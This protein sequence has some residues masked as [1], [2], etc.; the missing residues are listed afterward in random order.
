MEGISNYRQEDLSN[1]QVVF[2]SKRAD[3][4]GDGKIETVSL[5][6]TVLKSGIV[7]NNIKIIISNDVSRDINLKVNKG[8]NPK[9]FLGD[10]TSDGLDDVFVSIESGNTGREGFFYIYSFALNNEQKIFDYENFNNKYKYDVIYD[11]N[12]IVHVLSLFSPLNY[13]IN[14]SNRRDYLNTLY[15]KDGTL[16]RPTRGIVSPIIELRPIK[17]N[18][19]YNL[20]AIQRIVGYYNAD[21]LGMIVT[22]LHFDK[23]QKE[24]VSKTPYLI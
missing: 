12:Y 19:H 1:N 6:G 21:T 11:D 13:T 23:L 10:F 24:F 8:Y 7:A 2:D 22:P 3:I 17:D 4:N 20:E 16:K 18:N 5:T 9:L 14:I 15:N